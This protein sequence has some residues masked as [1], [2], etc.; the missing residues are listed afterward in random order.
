[1]GVLLL[2]SIVSVFAWVGIRGTLFLLGPRPPGTGEAA[3]LFALPSTEGAELALGSLEGRVV[4]LDFGI[5]SCPGCI[6]ATPKLNRLSRRLGP[7]GLAVV[8]LNQD[9]P[10]E[11]ERVRGF[12]A[13][14]RLRYPVLL[15]DGTVARRYGV[16][17]FP[18]VVLL[19]RNRRLRAV[20]QGPV[21][22]AR[23]EREIRA[24]L[25]EDV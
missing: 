23:L 20:H 24:L 25:A 4:L 15:D 10:Q 22:E 16:Y 14:R 6:G 7:E 21:T 19:D 11:L 9:G 3:P 13:Q 18:T 2:S 1:M 5:T 17:A 12:V 8:S